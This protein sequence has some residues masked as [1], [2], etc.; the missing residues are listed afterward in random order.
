MEVEQKVH[1]IIQSII[2]GLRGSICTNL[3]NFSCTVNNKLDSNNKVIIVKS[4]DNSKFNALRNQIGLSREHLLDSFQKT[5][6]V[7]SSL[8]EVDLNRLMFFTSDFCFVVKTIKKR[9]KDFLVNL[10]DEYTNYIAENQNKT[11]LPLIF[12]LYRIKFSSTNVK[13][14]II[15]NNLFFSSWLSNKKTYLHEIFDIKGSTYRK[16]LKENAI[17]CKDI[18]W[19]NQSRKI[20]ITDNNRNEI[21]LQIEKDTKFLMDH[22]ILDYSLVIGIQEINYDHFDRNIRSLFKTYVDENGSFKELISTK[23]SLNEFRT[24]EIIKHYSSDNVLN[25]SKNSLILSDQNNAKSQ[26]AFYIGI[27]DILTNWTFLKSMESFI[28][29]LCCQNISCKNPYEYRKRLLKMVKTHIFNQDNI[30][31]SDSDDVY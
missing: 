7:K 20:A 13:Y 18:D 9:E 8:G 26:N 12:G 2:K 6:T 23:D 1:F 17:E 24:E 27:V 22:C 15:M 10:L 31:I 3:P 30:E 16:M 11:L 29:T 19:I 28:G 25:K 14:I 21:I 5:Y 4:Y